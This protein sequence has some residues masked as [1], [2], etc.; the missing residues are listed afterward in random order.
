MEAVEI[1]AASAS[2]LRFGVG[3]DGVVLSIG[4]QIV[5]P[6]NGKIITAEEI[7]NNKRLALIG[8]LSLVVSVR[9][10]LTS[11]DFD[12][13]FQTRMLVLSSSGQIII[14]LKKQEHK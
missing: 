13:R 7:V 1:N 12:K 6:N 3:A 2:D 10:L 14:I 11:G 9:L 8:I 4:D 5:F